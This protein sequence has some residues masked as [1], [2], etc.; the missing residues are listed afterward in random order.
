MRIKDLVLPVFDVINKEATASATVKVIT[1]DAWNGIL[2]YLLHCE[3]FGDA[4]VIFLDSPFIEANDG[5]P[6]ETVTI[7]VGDESSFTGKCAIFA[8]SYGLLP[9]DE[10]A[11]AIRGCFEQVGHDLSDINTD[12]A[13]FKHVVVFYF[14]A[15]PTEGE[16]KIE[17]KRDYIPKEFGEHFTTM[18]TADKL[19]AKKIELGIN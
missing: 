2:D 15:T 8:I 4:E 16:V 11:I 7:K 17:L 12:P 19:Q 10:M 1:G 9:N 5:T 6:I 13:T 14:D 3:E 18:M